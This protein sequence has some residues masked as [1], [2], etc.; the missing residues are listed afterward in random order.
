[1]VVLR[2]WLAP[3]VGAVLRRALE[4][5]LEQV[6]AAGDDAEA[7]VAQRRA[8][9]LGLVAESAL[10]GG[11][12]P[13][14]R[15]DRF[16]VTAHVATQALASSRVLVNATPGAIS[17][18]TRE[19]SP[20]ATE[21]V[22]PAA[23]LDAGQPVIEQAGAPCG[24]GGGPPRRLRR[25][26]GGAAP[27]RR[28]RGARRRSQDSHYPHRPAP[29]PGGQGSQ[30]A[31]VPRLQ[32]PPPRRPSRRALGRG[33]ADATGKLCADFTTTRCMKRAFRC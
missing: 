28:Q 14:N 6:P 24:N 17:E 10:A 8:N 27:H 30:P 21:P 3:K 20:T 31:P 12:A 25:R 5:A 26:P 16:Q 22:V 4:A 23:D 32:L 1:M 13:G 15:G 19:L 7:T 9:A 2:G 33:R 29:R 18:E 11:L